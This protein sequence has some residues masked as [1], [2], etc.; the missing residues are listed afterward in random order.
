VHVHCGF[1]RLAEPG[2]IRKDWAADKAL[3]SVCRD[4][5]SQ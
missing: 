3:A 4:D 2:E 5:A 1:K